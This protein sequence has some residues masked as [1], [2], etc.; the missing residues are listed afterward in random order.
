MVELGI[1]T[2]SKEIKEKQDK[3]IELENKVSNLNS[4]LQASKSE[5]ENKKQTIKEMNVD[6]IKILNISQNLF[7]KEILMTKEGRE[8]K[9]IIEMVRNI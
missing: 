9:S 5:L 1:I 8:L 6:E 3:L 4:V 7:S 2:M